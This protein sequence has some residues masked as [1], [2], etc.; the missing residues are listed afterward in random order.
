MAEEANARV[1]VGASKPV[2]EPTRPVEAAEGASVVETKP[3]DGS[4]VAPADAPAE[5]KLS[6]IQALVANCL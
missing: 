3:A 2:D 1:A 4:D 5:G 6:F